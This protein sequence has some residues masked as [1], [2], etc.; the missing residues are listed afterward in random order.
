MDV[1]EEFELH[2]DYGLHEFVIPCILQDK[3]NAVVK[4]IGSDKQIQEPPQDDRLKRRPSAWTV[5]PKE[6]ED[7]ES[8]ELVTYL[9][10]FVG[11]KQTSEVINRL[12]SFKDDEVMHS[13]V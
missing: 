12:R 5:G 10:G 2:H 9:D 13:K 3:L 4:Y 8:R 1:A 7:D 6:D 11:P